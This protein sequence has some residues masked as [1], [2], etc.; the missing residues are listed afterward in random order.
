[1]QLPAVCEERAVVV[2]W[3]RLDSLVLED[4]TSSPWCFRVLPMLSAVQLCFWSGKVCDKGAM[5]PGCS[6]S[7]VNTASAS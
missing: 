1:M 5:W 3:G 6:R 7:W 2:L 4:A